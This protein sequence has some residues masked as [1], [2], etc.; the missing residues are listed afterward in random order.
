MCYTCRE[1]NPVT[2]A[3]QPV[4]IPTALSEAFCSVLS[5][6][7]ALDRTNQRQSYNSVDLWCKTLKAESQNRVEAGGTVRL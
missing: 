4:A 6:S 7:S 5:A 1:S 3:V 2:S